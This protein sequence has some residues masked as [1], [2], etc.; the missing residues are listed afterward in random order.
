MTHSASAPQSISCS[1][2]IQPY[3]DALFGPCLM[4]ID[5]MEGRSNGGLLVF[6]RPGVP[7]SPRN[8]AT[9][10]MSQG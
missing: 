7:I 4:R 8:V 9:Y 1:L 5:P 3:T 2:F 10:K 6:R